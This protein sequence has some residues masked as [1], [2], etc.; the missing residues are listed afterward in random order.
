VEAEFNDYAINGVFP[1]S[2]LLLFG[3]VTYEL[4]AGFWP[5]PEALNDDPIV[6]GK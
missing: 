6:A 2:D 3:R 5:M 1:F 4:M